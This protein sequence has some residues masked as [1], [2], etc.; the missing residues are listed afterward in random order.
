MNAEKFEEFKL[1]YFKEIN[2]SIEDVESDN[3]IDELGR[4]AYINAL[5]WVMT[6]FDDLEGEVIL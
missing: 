3:C 2:A 5:E 6:L 1:K 4:E